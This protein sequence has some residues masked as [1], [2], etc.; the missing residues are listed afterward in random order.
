MTKA[1][2]AGSEPIPVKV[3]EGKDYWWCSCGQS[4]SQPFCDGSHKVEGKFQPLKWTAPK[5]ATKY[6][7]TCKQTGHAPFCDGTHGTLNS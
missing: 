4:K 7:C 1:N 2:V 6:F 5:S 3:E